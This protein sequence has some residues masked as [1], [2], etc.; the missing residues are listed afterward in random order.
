[1]VIGNPRN[2][3][4]SYNPG[5][6]RTSFVVPSSPRGGSTQRRASVGGALGRGVLPH[7]PKSAPSPGRPSGASEGLGATKEVLGVIIGFLAFNLDFLGFPI[8]LL[9]IS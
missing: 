4:K 1:M 2:P 5:S 8:L 9:W 3:R 6:P 7:P